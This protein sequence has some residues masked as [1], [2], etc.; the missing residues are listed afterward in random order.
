MLIQCPVTGGCQTRMT[1]Q[2]FRLSCDVAR[3]DT[4]NHYC[5]QKCLGQITPKEL[6]F[7][8]LEDITMPSPTKTGTCQLCGKTDIATKKVNRYPSVCSSC[9]ALVCHINTR[10]QVVRQVMNDLHGDQLLVSRIGE[11]T[12]NDEELDAAREESAALRRQ[13]T[14]TQDRLRLVSEAQATTVAPILVRPGVA[15]PDSPMAEAIH[16]ACREV[17]QMLLE[18]NKAYGNSASEPVRVFSR[19]DPIEQINV[20]IDDKLSRMMRGHEYPGDDT[21]LDLIG[22]LVLKRAIVS[23]KNEQ[24]AA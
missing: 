14:E 23:R 13:L 1:A 21:E 4:R 16:N 11:T 12:P 24:A 3:G 19:V 18:K 17:E 15:Q 7:I 10:P 8:D 5:Q 6:T 22:Y 2:A 9:A 20:R